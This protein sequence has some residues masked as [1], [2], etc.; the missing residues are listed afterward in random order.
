MTDITFSI[1][2]DQPT[3]LED[4]AFLLDD[5]KRQYNIS[6]N[7]DRLPFE[8]AWPKLVNVALHGGGPNLSQI[9][10]IW[11]STL[12]LMNVLRQF[13]A[14]E[15]E[16]MGG[17]DAFFAPTWRNSILS[18]K[19]TAWGIPLSAYIYYIVYRRDLLDQAGVYEKTAFVSAE[20]MLETVE[21][22]SASKIK[23]PILLPSIQPF[24]A[25]IHISASWVWGA[26]GDFMSADGQ[27]VLLAE[28]AARKGLSAFYK[29]YRVLSPTDTNLA[30]D[31][32]LQRFLAGEAAAICAGIGSQSVISQCKNRSVL[33]NLGVAALPGIPWIGGSNLV[34]WNETRM[35]PAQEKAALTLIRFLANIKAQKEY[36][37]GQKVIP[38][39]IEALAEMEFEPPQLKEV[40]EKSLRTGRSYHAGPGWMRM[41]SELRYRFDAITTEVLSDREED[42]EK[43]LERHLVPVAD[44]FKLLISH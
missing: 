35:F 34:I 23:S 28:P 38:A 44:R 22:L 11:T 13:S 37:T 40:C 32:C 16:A 39:R 33:E 41:L 20:A 27:D 42:I 21:K 9:G 14:A 4:P 43:I 5:F 26:Q 19:L 10:S 1:Y 25:R 18:E 2:G 12:M 31:D 15:I 24:G 8:E 30:Y 7:L 6:V 29:L 17:V 3:V 36:A